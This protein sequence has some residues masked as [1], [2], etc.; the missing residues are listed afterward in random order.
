MD[1]IAKFYSMEIGVA[2]EMV[3]LV[4]GIQEKLTRKKD[5]Y[6]A[7]DLFDGKEVI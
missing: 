4:M 1:K 6:V 5:I 2:K 3:L 7:M